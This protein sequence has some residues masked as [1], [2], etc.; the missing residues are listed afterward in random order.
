MNRMDG[1]LT[2]SQRGFHAWKAGVLTVS[3]G[4]LV[5]GN[6]ALAKYVVLVDVA[7]FAVFYWQIA[8]AAVVLAGVVLVQGGKRKSSQ[9]TAA[10]WRYYLV[11]GVLG[12]SIPQSLGY[13]VLK[14]VPAGLF[15]MT[16]TLSPL[17]TFLA[18]SVYEGRLL[19]RY[20]ALG[21]LAG[22]A[23]VSLATLSGI[24]KGGFSPF[25][26]GLA[27]SVPVFL[28]ITN[29]FRDKAYPN[30]GDPLFLAAG[31]LGSQVVLLLPVAYGTGAFFLPSETILAV[32]PYLIALMAI[33]AIS[34]ILTFE[35]Y[36]HTDGVGFSQ[37]GYFA[38]LSGI[39]AGALFFDE[40]VS[41]MFAVSVLLLFAGMALANRRPA[42]TGCG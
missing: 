16:V 37:V 39:G 30:D 18:A 34:Y 15:T 21:L 22:L 35:L 33:T 8:G 10:H 24:G 13:V 12:I 32:A 31:T 42:Q 26:L 7:P 2:G 28:A 40:H 27:L 19:P 29:V 23:G 5:G 3:I 36:R 25:S 4:L 20:R 14:E 41:R 11:G 9:F 17:L 6:F 1:G 38:T